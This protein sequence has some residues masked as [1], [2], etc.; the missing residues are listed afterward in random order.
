MQLSTR[1]AELRREILKPDIRADPSKLRK[2]KAE[3][4]TISHKRR[5]RLKLL[6]SQRLDQL[7]ERVEQYKGGAKM[8]AAIKVLKEEGY[9]TKAPLIVHDEN[10][11]TIQSEQEAANAIAGYFQGLFS[12]PDAET[13]CSMEPHVSSVEELLPMKS[14]M[15]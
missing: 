15:L 3:A 2:L 10:G 8:F 5:K 14:S 4:N 9:S 12:A 1:H 7:A 13:L 11:Q 6:E